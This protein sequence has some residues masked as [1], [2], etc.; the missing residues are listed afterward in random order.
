[1]VFISD[2]SGR[3]ATSYLSSCVMN[4]NLKKEY[5]INNNYQYR[6]YLQRN[7]KQILENQRKGLLQNNNINEKCGHC[8]DCLLTK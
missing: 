7:A 3:F 8:R 2:S 4:N 5:N 6:L 1:M